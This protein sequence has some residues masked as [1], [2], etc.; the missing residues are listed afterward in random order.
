MADGQM[1]DG[2]P[3]APTRYRRPIW[4]AALA[5]AVTFIAVFGTWR[6]QVNKQED[7]TAV[8]A[9]GGLFQREQSD[10]TSLTAVGRLTGLPQ[11]CTGWVLATGGGDD[12]PAH[13]VTTARCVGLSDP[14]FILTDQVV[15]GA[16]LEVNDFARLTSAGAVNAVPVPIDRIVWA[17]VRGTDLAVLE[18]GATVGELAG[19]GVRAITPVATPEEGAELLVAGVPVEG[20]PEDQQFLRGSR[21]QL[22]PSAELL[23]GSLFWPDVEKMD[24]PGILDGSQGSTALNQAGA[25][26]AMVIGSTIGAPDGPDCTAARPCEVTSGGQSVHDN[27]SYLVPVEIVAGCFPDGPLQL[28]AD[29]G[30]EDPA[31]VVPA[32][33]SSRVGRP[34]STIEVTL[35]GDFPDP[36]PKVKQGPLGDVDCRV[37]EGWD[38]VPAGDADIAAAAPSSGQAWAYPVTLPAQE[39]RTLVCVGSATHPTEIVLMADGTPPDPA[40]I[41][42]TQTVVA[43]GVEV[44]PVADPPDLVTFRWLITSPGS[45]DCAAAEGYVEYSGSPETIQA[46]DLPATVCVIG[47]DEAGNESQPA[48]VKVT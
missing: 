25:A 1:Q 5:A 2:E 17:S 36:A 40:S 22:G 47:V 31:A 26:M 44:Q 13:A 39:G 24:C 33:P 32:V 14:S 43:G 10:G 41:E 27:T 18:L 15:R 8:T 34:G 42:L 46:A 45:D 48:A 35:D 11:P 29:C 12:V 23:S 21:C 4:L 19:L 20:I 6:T 9:P 30:L 3:T 37:L 28:G 16:T 7:L 38:D